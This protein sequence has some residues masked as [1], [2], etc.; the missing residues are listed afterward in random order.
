M[1]RKEILAKNLNDLMRMRD[2]SRNDVCDAIGV[3]YHTFTDW[4]KGRKFPRSDKLD[5]LANYFGIT[6]EELVGDGGF[7]RKLKE[8]YYLELIQ[9]RM[10][11]DMDY[12]IQL[13]SGTELLLETNRQLNEEGQKML[14]EYARFLLSKYKKED[15]Q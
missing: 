12:L 2:S 1:E 10:S 4:V 5:L 14:E 13:D 8:Q 3:N 7:E 15:G 11:P 9:K 6:V